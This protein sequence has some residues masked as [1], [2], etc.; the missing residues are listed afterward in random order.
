MPW[1]LDN[2]AV[3]W[4]DPLRTNAREWRRRAREALTGSVIASVGLFTG[5]VISRDAHDG[6]DS[7]QSSAERG[8]ALLRAGGHHHEVS[9]ITNPG[10][11]AGN[12]RSMMII[13][14]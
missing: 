14:P 12:S 9:G 8:A 7:V 1:A 10:R 13:S 11:A 4:A 2:R 3:K 6:R 5:D